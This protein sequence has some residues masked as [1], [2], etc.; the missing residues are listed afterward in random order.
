MCRSWSFSI[1]SNV[2]LSS[3]CD[4][5]YYGCLNTD[6]CLEGPLTDLIIVSN[7][8]AAFSLHSLDHRLYKGMIDCDLSYN[9][10]NPS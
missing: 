6:L 7:I 4:A 8:S 5:V 9:Q 3:W 10:A 1:M 2:R